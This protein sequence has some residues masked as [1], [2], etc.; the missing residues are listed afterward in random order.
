M[1]TIL[2]RTGVQRV[3]L[4]VV[5]FAMAA[6]IAYADDAQGMVFYDRNGN[7]VYDTGEEGLANI[8]ISNGRD[9][10]LSGADGRYSI[11]VDDDTIIFVIKPQNWMTATDENGVPRFYYVHKP[12]GSPELQGVGVAPTGDLPESVDF[13]L[14]RSEEADSFEVLVFGDP[15]VRSQWETDLLV[16]DV[17]DQIVT[18]GTDAVM[19]LSLGDICFDHLEHL[20]SVAD[21]MGMLGM[22]N[23]YV[24]GNHD[25]N[26][27]AASD[28]Y[29]DET[30]ER[31]FGPAT[32]SMNYGPVHFI[33]L[34]DVLWHPK[35]EEKKAHYTG[36]LTEKQLEFVKNDLALL[37]PDQLIVYMFHIP[38]Q[39]MTNRADFLRLFEGHPNALGMSA[40]THTMYH[41]FVGQDAGWPGDEPH[42]HFVNM[43]ACGAWWGGDIDYYGIPESP[44]RDGAPN[45]YTL[46]TF[47]GNQYELEFV[48]ARYPES[49]QMYIWAPMGV[50]AATASTT[51][52]VYANVFAASERS[53]VEMRIDDDGDWAAMERVSA[54]RK[55][56][57]EFYQKEFT[58]TLAQVKRYSEERPITGP[59]PSKHLWQSQLPDGLSSGYH[60]I[61]VRTTDMFGHT[62]TSCRGVRVK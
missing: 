10:V 37:H 30:W 32:Y 18:E 41:T 39:S 28:D 15:Q 47:S 13:P 61:Y 60:K 23:Y 8:A 25:E 50:D 1:N 45:G 55:E 58:E 43:T 36:A 9:M 48:P 20:Q 33:M 42:H 59:R 22:P 4:L 35:T 3:L 56:D 16:H 40:H 26:Y 12:H 27:D 54:P 53:T 34:D 31:V 38:L 2:Q 17:L 49:F 14:Y 19:S 6:G 24:L 51:A 44:G 46:A 52:N 5:V 11:G 62:Y 7:G 57:V 21:A 29:A